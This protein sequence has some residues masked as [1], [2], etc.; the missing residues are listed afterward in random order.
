MLRQFLVFIH[1]AGVVVWV[2]GM[3]FAHFC[4]RPAALR[5]LEPPQRLPLWA[6]TLGAFLRYTAVAVALILLSGFAIL[7]EVGLRQAPMGWHVMMGTGLVMAGIFAWVYGVLYPRLRRHSAA[8]A[9]PEAGAALNAIRRL[10]TTNLVLAL[11]TVAAA[12]FLR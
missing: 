9:W 6:A 2:G 1:L 3:F 8:G 12:L 7:F 11:V 10:V 5:L 4:L